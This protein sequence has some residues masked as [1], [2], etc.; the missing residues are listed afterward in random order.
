[1]PRLHRLSW[2]DRCDFPSARILQI[3]KEVGGV[4]LLYSVRVGIGTGHKV[5]LWNVFVA[6]DN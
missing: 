6:P 4:I 3:V 1:M 2:R 5:P